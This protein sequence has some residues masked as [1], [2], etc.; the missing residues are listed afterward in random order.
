MKPLS[1]E[2]FVKQCMVE[3]LEESGMS[4]RIQKISGNRRKVIGESF[5]KSCV[6]EVLKENLIEGFD[7]LSQ[8]PNIA[9]ENPYPEWNAKMA[10]LEEDVPEDDDAWERYEKG[11]IAGELHRKN[12]IKP[13]GK[14]DDPVAFVGYHD[15]F[16][17]KP[18]ASPDVVRKTIKDAKL[19][20]DYTEISTN[21]HGRYAQ[22][23]GAG[24]FDPR[25][26][27]KLN[28]YDDHQATITR[29]K[30]EVFADLAKNGFQRMGDEP[31]DY[32]EYYL[33]GFVTVSIY[34]SYD[35]N[36]AHIERYYDNEMVDN[37][38]GHHID[39]KIPVPEK[40]NSEY[41]KKLVRYVIAL[42]KS[43]VGDE[44]IFGGV[45]DFE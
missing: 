44:S 22:E 39:V 45:D 10:K 15:A 21:P 8:G 34:I 40:Y 41:V 32:M 31:R 29:V 12:G 25:T 18:K 9:K 30:R 43:G 14:V 4:D 3:V 37:I 24:Q 6:V 7:P 17:G 19:T 28:E 5:I 36:A 13:E 33:N 35:D 27:G 11:Y 20:D 26:F 2:S 23:A 1:L 42:K 16:T 38:P